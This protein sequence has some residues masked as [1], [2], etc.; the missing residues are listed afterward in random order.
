MSDERKWKGVELIPEEADK[1]KAFL[2]ENDIEMD[3]MGCYNLTLV[4][5]KVNKV[6]EQKIEDF[7]ERMCI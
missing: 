6:E 7:L 2:H 5:A 1:L 3:A 4:R